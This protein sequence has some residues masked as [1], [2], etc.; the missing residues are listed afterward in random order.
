M[1]IET[2]QADFFLSLFIIIAISISGKIKIYHW[3]ISAEIQIKYL[4]FTQSQK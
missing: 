1:D 2:F 4:E 3:L